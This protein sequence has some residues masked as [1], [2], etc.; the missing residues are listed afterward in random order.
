M[1]MAPSSTHGSVNGNNRPSM[2]KHPWIENLISSFE[3][4]SQSSTFC[5]QSYYFQMKLID[6]L[7]IIHYYGHCCYYLVQ[8]FN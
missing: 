5:V 1:V 8:S 4:H 6:T 2:A 7:C 3:L